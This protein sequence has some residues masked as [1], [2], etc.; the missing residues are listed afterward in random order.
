MKKFNVTLVAGVSMAATSLYMSAHG[1]IDLFAGAGMVIAAFAI[2]MELGKV[3][4]LIYLISHWRLSFLTV[5]L[6]ITTVALSAVSTA[7][8][9]G[10]LGQAYGAG[11][12]DA[13]LG[14]ASVEA[15]QQE[16]RTLEGDRDRLFQMVESIPA[17]HS[18][19]R[20]QILAG[21]QP[22]IASID[23]TL[24]VKRAELSKTTTAQAGVEQ[25]VGQLK[26]AAAAMGLSGDQLARWIIGILACLLDP[27]A[28][29]LILASGAHRKHASV[30]KEGAGFRPLPI[31]EGLLREADTT[32]ADRGPVVVPVTREW[33]TSQIAA[34]DAV[35]RESQNASL[36]PEENPNT[37]ERGS[38]FEFEEEN[39]GD[40]VFHDEGA[41]APAGV[42]PEDPD[43]A[44]VELAPVAVADAP[45]PRR[46]LV[47]PPSPR[48]SSVG[49]YESTAPPKRRGLLLEPQDDE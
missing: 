47:P 19:N 39:H 25:D 10:Y 11:Q 23:S 17:E 29:L 45:D 21:V 20:R 18:T 3:G 9:Y 6:T 35:I 49:G 40:A 5:A 41:P 33:V 37:F 30:R 2:V 1:L 13:V 8:V 46:T 12:K 34:I 24:S 48:W 7:G 38:D 14:R 31:P 36:D 43:Q 28:L 32:G 44:E 16:I 27:L 4:S 42:G 26:Y 15:L 22:Q